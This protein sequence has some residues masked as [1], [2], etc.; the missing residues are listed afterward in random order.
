MPSSPSGE[1]ATVVIECGWSIMDVSWQTEGKTYTP[2]DLSRLRAGRILLN[3]PPPLADDERP[4]SPSQ[5]HELMLESHIR[6]T[7]NPVSV[8]HCIVQ[9]IYRNIGNEP[10]KFLRLARLASI[11]FLKAG[12]A[13]EHI[14]ELTL[15]PITNGSVHVKFR[16]RRRQVASNVEPAVIEVEGDCPLKE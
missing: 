2:E 1:V 12:E 3:D 6:G 8:E 9:V 13:V 5:M 14:L 15:G 16:G 7:S 4:V 11:Y 10:E